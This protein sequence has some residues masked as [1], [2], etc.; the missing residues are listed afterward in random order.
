M[1]NFTLERNN[2]GQLVLIDAEGKR[3]SGVDVLRAFP[4]TEPTKSISIVD[5]E[6]REA[7]F[8]ASLDDVPQPQ[9]KILEDELAHREFFPVILRVINKPQDSE[10]SEWKV[11]T[12]RGT[13]TFQLENADHVHRLRGDHFTIQDS[14]GIRYRIPD[15]TKLDAHSRHVMERFL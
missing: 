13:T 9:R 5:S 7:L 1:I 15:A 10:P 8:I 14:L 2:F 11:E 12:D 6:G 3:H 4:L